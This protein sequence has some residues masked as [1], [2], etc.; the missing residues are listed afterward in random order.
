MGG[1]AQKTLISVS[2]PMN[3]AIEVFIGL[4][5]IYIP[6]IPLGQFLILPLLHSPPMPA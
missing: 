2:V 5:A 3:T 1:S 4:S 6:F